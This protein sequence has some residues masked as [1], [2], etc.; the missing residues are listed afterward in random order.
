[1]TKRLFIFVILLFCI[2]QYSAIA[3]DDDVTVTLKGD[4][5]LRSLAIKYFG[6]PND[7]EVILFYNGYQSAGEVN[8]GAT[9]KIPVGLYKKITMQ[10]DDAQQA[11]TQANNEGAGILAKELV[12]AAISAQKESVE[13]K[14]KGQ[15]DLAFKRASDAVS[16]ANNAI[17]QTQTKRVKS[18]SAILSEKKG[19]VQSRKKDQ[20][21][22]YD[23]NK[24]Q[25]LIEK[26]HI[27]TLSS[28]S[29]E[30]AFV[31][32]SKLNINENSLAVI[33]AMK[34]DLIK[35]T[36]T[37]SVVVLQGDIMAYLS[38]QGNKNQVN[39]SVPGV[40][41]EIRSRSFRASRD[42]NNVT[43]FANYDGEIDVKA[44]GAA[45]TIGKNEGT[46]IAPGE[47]PKEARKLLDPPKI[48]SPGPKEKFYTGTVSIQW[49][50]IT[51]AKGYYLQIA[52]VRSFSD[53]IIDQNISGKAGFKWNSNT[54]GVFYIRVASIDKEDFTGTFSSAVEFYI[55]KDITP[56]FLLVN[57]PGNEE[58]VYQ[59]VITISGDAEA[60]ADLLINSDSAT[61]DKSGK[62]SHQYKLAPG[63]NTILIQAIDKAGN[64]SKTE[65]IIYFN[66][67]DNLINLN[68]KSTV[69][70][71]MSEYALTGS[72]KPGCQISING[73]LVDLVDYQFNHIVYLKDGI[74][75][76]AIDAKSPKGNTQSLTVSLTLD[77]KEPEVE[78]EDIPSFTKD[79]TYEITGTL[80]EECS[81][82][83]N[84]AKIPVSELRFTNSF[85]LTE[86]DNYLEL[87]AEDLAGNQA[88]IEIEIFRDT[89]KPKILSATTVPQ[90]VKG[91]ELIQIKVAARDD[92]VG[93][94][95]NGK[96]NL[97]ISGGNQ[98]FSGM[99]SLSSGGNYSGTLMIPPGVQ[100]QLVFNELII[101]DYLGNQAEYPK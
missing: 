77:Q 69:V 52:P 87:V 55:D 84:K 99:L 19:K 49:E 20:T 51:A 98:S 4:E 62:F 58:S 60:D 46:S 91:G 13:L 10:L 18:I 59:P 67:D 65:R 34:Q 97:G 72:T 95:R 48:L 9:L 47:K 2:F 30:I 94:A 86:G 29:G 50:R 25:E 82:I 11:I 79:A 28:A 38:S 90:Q 71:N 32:G 44:A 22:W 63:K 57:K 41:T 16:S 66:A 75:S 56:P 36:N 15:L 89:E 88:V 53:R 92:G 85:A 45:V 73:Q 35:N 17:Q 23:S 3:A 76:V 42:E 7:W 12:E 43:K 68:S 33:E 8:V 6:E 26:E 5:T 40:E 64:V 100:G 37:S 31:D 27:R 83:I 24:N 39:V 61:I 93:L 78:I 81:I 1:M 14:K 101:Q 54:T 74:N 80:N 96:F 70:T 21:I